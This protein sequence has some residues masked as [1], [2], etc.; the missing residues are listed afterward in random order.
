MQ[1]SIVGFEFT[2]DH[3]GTNLSALTVDL[4]FDH[5]QDQPIIVSACVSPPCK[6]GI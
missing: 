4:E 2:I 1:S 5:D 3:I 6:G